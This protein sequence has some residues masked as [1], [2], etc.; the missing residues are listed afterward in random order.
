MNDTELNNEKE[1]QGLL[2]TADTIINVMCDSVGNDMVILKDFPKAFFISLVG[3]VLGNARTDLLRAEEKYK[4]TSSYYWEQRKRA[5]M[6]TINTFDKFQKEL[7]SAFRFS[8]MRHRIATQI[9]ETY[10]GSENADS[11]I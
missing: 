11:I 2:A 7:H 10:E 5:L 6:H 8:E 4:E 9:V 1:Y 3:T